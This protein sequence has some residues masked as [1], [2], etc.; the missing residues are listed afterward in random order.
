MEFNDIIMGI[1]YIII[2]GTLSL[3][4]FWEWCIAMVIH[5]T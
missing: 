2:A 4:S 5:R 3:A 1:S